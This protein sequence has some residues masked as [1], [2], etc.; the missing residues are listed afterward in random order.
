MGWCWT[1]AALRSIGYH[2]RPA[3]MSSAVA[4]ADGPRWSSMSSVMRNLS[5]PIPRPVTW[6]VSAFMARL[7]WIDEA[8]ASDYLDRDTLTESQ[9]TAAGPQRQ[10]FQQ[11]P[12]PWTFLTSGYF[13]GFMI[14]VRF[15]T[16]GH[17]Q[18]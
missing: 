15:I 2:L 4:V 6:A 11:T 13:I 9:R 12:V 18:V 1:T 16:S 3:S 5:I 14:F 7:R 17:W 10:P 8:T